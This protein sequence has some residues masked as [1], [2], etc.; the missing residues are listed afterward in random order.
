[1]FSTPASSASL[2]W[3]LW[4]FDGQRVVAAYNGTV[5][6]PACVHRCHS[7]ASYPQY[8]Q[9]RSKPAFESYLACED[10][11]QWRHTIVIDLALFA[12]SADEWR[13]LRQ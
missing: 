4:N 8:V 2:L 5:E 3:T 9:L 1:M 10:I 13:R 12:A 7:T 11:C 6:T